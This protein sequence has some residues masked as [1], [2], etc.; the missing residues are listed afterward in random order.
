MQHNIK[1]HHGITTINEPLEDNSINLKS[2]TTIGLVVEGGSASL[3]LFDL[4]DKTKFLTLLEQR[5]TPNFFENYEKLKNE[6]NPQAKFLSLMFIVETIAEI[7]PDAKIIIS[8]IPSIDETEKNY[9]KNKPKETL[10]EVI[11]AQV[12]AAVANFKNSEARFGIKPDIL[13]A[14]TL[15]DFEV[16]KALAKVGEKLNAF[17]YAN[18]VN[19]IF[20]K[21]QAKIKKIVEDANKLKAD[22]YPVG[23]ADS[24][25]DY[26]KFV[27]TF[28]QSTPYWK[29]YEFLI[30]NPTLIT[31]YLS[32]FKDCKNLSFVYA[33]DFNINIREYFADANSFAKTRSHSQSSLILIASAR[34][35]VDAKFGWHKSMSN[36]E[37]IFKNIKITYDQSTNNCYFLPIQTIKSS[38]DQSPD[39]ADILNEKGVLLFKSINDLSIWG[40]RTT[41]S[42]NKDY[43][44]ETYTRT[45]FKLKE[46][47]AKGIQWAVDKPIT[48]GLVNDVVNIIEQALADL[49]TQGKLLGAKIWV[50]KPENNLEN[51]L[52]KEQIKQ[53]SF[54]F[55]YKFTAVPPLEQLHLRHTITGEYIDDLIKGIK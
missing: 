40:S 17:V 8:T 42:K 9:N 25:A 41:F 34:S 45:E 6:K 29:F 55:K 15:D 26:E 5:K 7:N 4:S 53:G 32:E 51:R 44:F 14:P 36:I 39:L 11:K 31:E 19:A 18:F 12:L 27:K 47:I 3:S 24:V 21:E 35:F 46:I 38:E 22:T 30:K 13:I 1:Y 52:L 20:L 50:K 37:D 10:A 49:V 16:T 43:I 28:R 54:S 2:A 48:A 23:F 33:Q